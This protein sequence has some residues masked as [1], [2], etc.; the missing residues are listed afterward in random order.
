MRNKKIVFAIVSVF[1]F[2]GLLSA[3]AISHA[4]TGKKTVVKKVVKKK[5][6]KV[7]PTAVPVEKMIGTFLVEKKATRVWYVDPTNQKRY[8]LRNNADVQWLIDNVA[9]ALS[10]DELATIPKTKTASTAIISHYGGSLVKDEN[11]Y[12][13]YVGPASGRR[14]P[15]PTFASAA[16]LAQ[17]FGPT[18]DVANLGK[19]FMN[20]EQGIVDP[21]FPTVAYA[22]YDGGS[23]VQGD[24]SQALLPL[25]SVSKLMT[26]LVLLDTIKE[27]DRQ[28]QI[29]AE[30]I[31]YPRR[32][33]GTTDTSEVSLRTGDWVYLNDLWVAMLVASSNQSAVILA[34]ATGLSRANFTK[35]MNE[36][37]T[38][39]GL[40]KTTFYEM[41]GLDPRNVSTAE[42]MA[43]FGAAAFAQQ[44]V[45]DASGKDKYSFEVVMPNG[46]ARTVNVTNRNTSLMAF[47]A[48]AAKTGYLIE[49]QRTAVLK[50]GSIVI[51]IMHALSLPQRNQIIQ[52]L[53]GV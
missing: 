2:A 22:M 36:K 30:E 35:K 4:A 41:T 53:L 15:L 50:K 9:T 18:V 43:Q 17:R 3:P 10:A 28:V 5:V 11:G 6:V 44:E 31:S 16:A 37:A 8:L 26:A 7:K 46:T 49:A 48:D 1:I 34:D 33:A 39:L 40:K 19:V 20:D 45:L 24:H 25:A 29:T 13:W 42:E 27:W 47:G 38:A 23:L 12:A 21:V 51:A 52:R 32:T 14:Y